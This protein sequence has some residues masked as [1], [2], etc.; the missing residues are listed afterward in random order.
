MERKNPKSQISNK[1]VFIYFYLLSNIVFI[2]LLKDKYKGSKEEE[3]DIIEAYN[4]H[5]GNMEKVFEWIMFSESEISQHRYLDI[6]DNL[7][8]Q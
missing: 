1:N 5:K 2:F 3:D 8:K 4:K 7:I 6:I